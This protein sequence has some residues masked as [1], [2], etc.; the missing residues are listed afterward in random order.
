MS[1][2]TELIKAYDSGWVSVTRNGKVKQVTSKLYVGQW[3]ARIKQDLNS[4]LKY[5][6]LTMLAEIDGQ[7]ITG[8]ELEN[9]YIELN[10]R[11]WDISDKDAK[12]GLLNAAKVNRYHPVQDYLRRIEND[13]NVVAADINKLS[14]NYLK[15]EK[16]L[17]D[18]MLAACLIGDVQRAF[19]HGCQMDYLLTLK[20]KQGIGKSTFWRTLAGEWFCDSYQESD[21]DLRLAIGTCWMF[22]IQELETMTARSVAGKVK[23]LITTR[24]DVFRPPY[25]SVTEKFPRASIFVGSVNSDDFLRDET[26]SRRFWVI[27]VTERVDI[28]RLRKDRDS[29]WKA[30]V[31]AWRSGRK[32]NLEDQELIESES[33]NSGY[34]SEHP[35]QEPLLNWLKSEIGEFTAHAAIIGS[36]IRTEDKV[37]DR[38]LRQC[39]VALRRLGY[40]PNPNQKRIGKTRVRLWRKSLS[41]TQQ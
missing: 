10:E 5:N 12:K 19:Q 18:S 22:E 21:K 40:E 36:G 23:A 31:I 34:E 33:L 13:P 8:E 38:D 20:G 15:T 11:G 3:S 7:P 4:R 9:I 39:H 29:I 14:S 41:K 30:V 17:Y 32:P 35:F 26:G 24:E 27:E 1:K 2:L 28:E 37:T 25:G 16:K 6:D